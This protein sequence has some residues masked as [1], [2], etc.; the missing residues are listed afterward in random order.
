MIRSVKTAGG[1]HRIPRSEVERL[2]FR[3][4]GKTAPERAL[5]KRRVSGRNQ[6]VG[7]IESVRISGLLAEVTISL[8]NQDITLIITSTSAR[9]MH[10]KPGQTCCSHPATGIMIL[11]V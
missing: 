9:E 5:I 2:L 4:I 11:R 6:P 10:L 8:G 3:T 7:R 1:H